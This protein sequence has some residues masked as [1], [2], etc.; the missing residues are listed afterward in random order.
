[1]T[2]KRF[3]TFRISVRRNRESVCSA[4]IVAEPTKTI[5][6]TSMPE[7]AV[8]REALALIFVLLTWHALED[9]DL[10]NEAIKFL[11]KL[12]YDNIIPQLIE[13]TLVP[14]PDDEEDE[15]L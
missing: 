8:A 14:P 15:W 7:H 11:V 1:M 6:E 3:P 12:G 10:K 2:A 4:T 5:V 9:T 13:S